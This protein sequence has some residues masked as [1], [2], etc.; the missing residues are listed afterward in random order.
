MYWRKSGMDARKTP[1]EL[2]GIIDEV[3]SIPGVSVCAFISKTGTP[4]ASYF[5]GNE[6]GNAL[7]SLVGVMCATVISSAEGVASIVDVASPHL[8]IARSTDATI[9][10]TS[11]GDAAYLIAILKDE[12]EEGIATER[13]HAIA[14]R[15]G[16][17]I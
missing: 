6:S 7:L 2:S 8:I 13:I 5:P 1:Q 4:L 12:N 17:V 14:E 15:I 9:V 11:A 16:S 10:I 3:R